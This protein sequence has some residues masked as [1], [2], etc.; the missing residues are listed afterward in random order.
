MQKKAGSKPGFQSRD[1]AVELRSDP[2][3]VL[4]S[5]PACA[6]C[7]THSHF[8]SD[9]PKAAKLAKAP[10]YEVQKALPAVPAKPEKK[11]PSEVKAA[12]PSTPPAQKKRKQPQAPQQVATSSQVKE[13]PPETSSSKGKKRG[14]SN[15]TIAQVGI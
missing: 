2:V 8:K 1:F 9:C 4:T 7:S 5:Y 14:I 3:V 15:P 6:A 11:K 10:C 12:A 13:E